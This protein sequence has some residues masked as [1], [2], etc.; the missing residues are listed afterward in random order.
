MSPATGAPPA[1]GWHGKLPALGDFATRRLDG[2]FVQVWDAWLATGLAALARQPGWLDAYLAS[3]VW[4][5]V[6]LPGALPAAQGAAPAALAWAGVL[7]PSVDRVGRYYPLTLAH[8]LDGLPATAG[9]V[10][11]LLRW[12]AAL[13]DAAADALHGDWSIDTL[14]AQLARIGA[15]PAAAQ[16]RPAGCFDGRGPIEALSLAAPGDPGALLAAQAA[17]LWHGAMRGRAFWHAAAGPGAPRL[18]V[19]D[20]LAPELPAELFGPGTGPVS[21]S[22]FVA[23]AV[24]AARPTPGASPR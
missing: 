13:D 7:M 10:D 12:L 24:L 23:A 1:A 9:A 19:S 14:D 22:V 3:P 20:G 21:A 17:A 11:A 15:P 8:P 18:L 16:P 4:R 6:L 5:F 2:A